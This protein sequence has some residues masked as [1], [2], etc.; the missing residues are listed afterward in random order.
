MLGHYRSW[1][2]EKNKLINHRFEQRSQHSNA[3]KAESFFFFGRSLNCR[4]CV[5]VESRKNSQR[6]KSQIT[7]KVW[8]V[9]FLGL[10]FSYK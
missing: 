2:D 7:I 3:V 6:L 4:Y 9:Q 8:D 1:T 5:Q 10:L